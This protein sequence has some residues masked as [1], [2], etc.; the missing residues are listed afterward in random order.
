MARVVNYA[1]SF[2]DALLAEGVDR[3][4][5]LLTELRVYKPRTDG[6]GGNYEL[7]A[8]QLRKKCSTRDDESWATAARV[9]KHLF[10]KEEL[11]DWGYLDAKGKPVTAFPPGYAYFEED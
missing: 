1:K 5:V 6:S 11:I 7:E 10:T 2:P 4:F 3:V 8:R 9:E